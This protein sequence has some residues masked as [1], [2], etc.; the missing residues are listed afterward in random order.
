MTNSPS[1]VWGDIRFAVRQIARAPLF[2]GIVIAVIALGIGT[3]AA[4][5]TVLQLYAWN[6][7]PG[8]DRH[9][10]LVRLTPT[11]WNAEAKGSFPVGLT[12]ATVQELGQQRDVFS[13]VTAWTSA[14]LAVDLG[15]GPERVRTVYVTGNYFRV[16]GVSL[17]AGPGLPNDIDQS[18]LPVA[19]ISQSVWMS[20]FD[21]SPAAI[22]KTIRVM[23]QPFT[24][25]GVAAAPF[26]GVDV[27]A[28]ASQMIW[29]PLSAR[30]QLHPDAGQSRNGATLDAVGRL[31]EGV[32]PA[33]V[34]A[35]LSLVANR[36][37]QQ[38][39][40]MYDRLAFR[41]ERLLGYEQSESSRTELIAA[42]L[43]VAIL[44]I[45]ITCTNVSVLLLG[46]AVARR[47]E[48][49]IRLAL[50]GTRSRII[51][52]LLTESLLLAFV[53]AAIGL[54]LYMLGVEV[55]YAMVPEAIYGLSPNLSSFVYAALFAGLTTIAFGLAPALHAT[56]TDVAEVIKN[57]GGQSIRRSRLQALF[58]VA[59]LACS[60]PVLIVTS[61]VLADIRAHSGGSATAPASV[62]TMQADLIRPTADSA[63]LAK[64]NDIESMRRQLAAI[65][66][67]QSVAI[68]ASGDPAS[69]SA[70][71]DGTN[72][73]DV[74]RR[75]VTP[76]YPAALGIPVRGS[77]I[78]TEENRPGSD[79]V[80]VN[81]A[82]AKSL[83]PGQDAVGKRLVMRERDENHRTTTLRVIGVAA[84][85]AY[86]NEPASP[87]VLLPM[88]TRPTIKYTEIDIR[89]SGD[90]RGFVP[91]IRET[92]RE[93]DPLAA[94][95]SV[96]T[97]AEQ[98]ASRRREDAEAN[99]AALAVGVVAL[100]LASLGLY[101]I[102]AY[103]VA[104]RTREIGI[105]LAVGASSRDVVRQFFKHGVMMA[106]IGIVIGAP[107]TVVGI[108]AAEANPPQFTLGNA[109]AVV[110]VVIALLLVAA[111]ASWLPARRAARVDPLSA[112]RSE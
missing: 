59:Q 10:P 112:L 92:I 77:A 28:M 52:Q 61:L 63:R 53:G 111:G 31:A 50:G 76:G 94:V 14:D 25:V 54:A 62:V 1:S 17:A 100:L 72:G 23:N 18:S 56:R 78:G 80:V 6:P 58:I 66:G 65:S 102:I 38:D 7:A 39:P 108:Q 41:A 34:P 99:A 110:F 64:P 49:G 98:A 93:A 67:V 30:S 91:R 81:A 51:R 104:Q 95:R 29:L 27:E 44:V 109:A 84:Q 79:A 37:G 13:A 24:I 32:R 60:Q 68:S 82:L 97:L 105:R 47:R 4:L 45:A 107:L 2:S 35:R 36:L 89:T 15:P 57:S 3:N 22:G 40:K 46:R 87:E 12:A 20:S 9:A 101:A 43:V 19:V 16:L 70:S 106:A 5:M 86:A 103:S 55:A 90:A 8:I 26:G 88:A 11:A 85:P 33:N 75:Y 83:W 21:G 96:S 74:K 69:F 48:V 42:F 71:G 73:L